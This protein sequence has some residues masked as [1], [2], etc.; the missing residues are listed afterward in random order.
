[1]K[2]KFNVSTLKESTL[3]SNMIKP[4]ES[5]FLTDA[6]L[7]KIDLFFGKKL[8]FGLLRL[9]RLICIHFKLSKQK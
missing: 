2:K 1:M 5:K 9:S 3:I 6:T 4:F 8:I 7:Q